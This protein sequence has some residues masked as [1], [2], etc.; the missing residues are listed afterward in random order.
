M[1]SG[2]MLNFPTLLT[3]NPKTLN[4]L[5]SSLN[6]T[7]SRISSH[8]H[9]V[10]LHFFLHLFHRFLLPSYLGELPFF[11][12]FFPSILLYFLPSFLPSFLLIFLPSFLLSFL[13]I[14]LPSFFPSFLPS[15]LP[16]FPSFLPSLAS[17]LPSLSLHYSFLLILYIP[18]SSLLLLC[19]PFSS[20]RSFWAL[21]HIVVNVFHMIHVR[22]KY[23]LSSPF[24]FFKG[25]INS[26]NNGSRSDGYAKLTPSFQKY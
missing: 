23:L 20:L 1:L 6:S 3:I 15:Y 5:F 19:V 26:G 9:G 7:K 16:S 14:F 17:F 4:S 24:F 21:G 11:P 18:Y 25:G 2:K 12:S 22:V 8:F 10:H 13:L